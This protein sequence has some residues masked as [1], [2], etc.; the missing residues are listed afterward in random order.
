VPGWQSGVITLEKMEACTDPSLTCDKYTEPIKTPYH[1]GANDQLDTAIQVK[2][3]GII[4][5]PIG[6]AKGTKEKLLLL[7]LSS[8]N[9][10]YYLLDRKRGEWYRRAYDYDPIKIPG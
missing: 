7:Y 1:S 6:I 8:F 4:R 2:L 10:R 5:F 9:P 3:S